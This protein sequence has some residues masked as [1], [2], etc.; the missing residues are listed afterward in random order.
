MQETYLQPLYSYIQNAI[1]TKLDLV[2]II[3]GPRLAKYD[4]VLSYSHI[5]RVLLYYNTFDNNSVR[6]SNRFGGNDEEIVMRNQQLFRTS[7]RFTDTSKIVRKVC[8]YSHYTRAQVDND[9]DTNF[10]YLS[11]HIGIL[12]THYTQIHG[13]IGMYNRK[14]YDNKDRF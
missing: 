6:N 8:L 11:R 7:A 9:D 13:T 12:N 1:P 4:A 5:V 2:F 10:R 14:L 3:T